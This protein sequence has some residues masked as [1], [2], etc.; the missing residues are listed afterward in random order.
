[1]L[2]KNFSFLLYFFCQ[3]KLKPKRASKTSKLP[4]DE[5]VVIINVESTL[6]KS[7]R[8]KF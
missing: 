8:E 1:M 6:V 7:R 4:A 5:H 3:D 2:I